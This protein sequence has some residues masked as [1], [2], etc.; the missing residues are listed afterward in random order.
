MRASNGAAMLG[1]VPKTSFLKWF[2]DSQAS[3]KKIT[4]QDMNREIRD[5]RSSMLWH[6]S[7][8]GKYQSKGDDSIVNECP[9]T[10]SS[11]ANEAKKV[12]RES[13]HNQ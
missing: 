12:R 4:Q 5:R 6:F 1:L 3:R 13:L 9:I 7:K 11:I 10:H 8:A 2:R